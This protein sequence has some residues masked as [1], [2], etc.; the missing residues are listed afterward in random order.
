MVD[1][2]MIIEDYNKGMSLAGCNRKYGF[3]I[4]YI[5]NLLV[6]NNIHIRTRNEQNRFNPQN[7]RKYEVND[8]YFST[9][10]NNS[11]YLLGFLAADGCVYAKNNVIKLCLSS[12]DKDFLTCVN[13]EIESNFPIHDYISKD[14]YANS[15]LRIS[16]NQIKK[17]LAQYNIIPKKT[18]S[19]NFPEKIKEEFY[20]D[21]IRG[22]FDGDGTICKAGNSIRFSICAYNKEILVKII[23]I[24]YKFGIPKV[25]IYQYNDKHLYYFQYSTQ[26]VKKIYNL[27]YS[28]KDCLCLSRKKDKFESLLLMK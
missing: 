26:S 8:Y 15:E 5:K 24:F 10:T 1:T 19:F 28:Q 6:E 13:R 4:P 27:L 20:L 11:C 17:D 9:Q 21:F 18:Y 16:S 23:D 3:S 12:I 7:Q 25:N 22:Y 2:S 14:G